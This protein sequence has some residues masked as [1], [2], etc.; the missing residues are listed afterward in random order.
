MQEGVIKIA[1]TVCA[2][3]ILVDESNDIPDNEQFSFGIRFFDD[4]KMIVREEFLDFAEI[5]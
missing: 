3:S 1:K 4:G 2:D 5:T